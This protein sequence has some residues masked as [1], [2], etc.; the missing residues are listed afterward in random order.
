R[1]GSGVASTPAFTVR[2]SRLASAWN[3]SR[4]G[5]VQ[6]EIAPPPPNPITA[7]ATLSAELLP[8]ISTNAG[9]GTEPVANT[10]D[11]PLTEPIGAKTAC[12]V[13]YDV[14]SAIAPV[15]SFS[16]TRAPKNA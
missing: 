15:R 6:P 3:G 4:D 9:L 2:A 8:A 14:T 5:L 13:L 1:T 10:F 16:P 12:A 11:S 7:A